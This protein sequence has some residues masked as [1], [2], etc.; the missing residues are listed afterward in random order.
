MKQ[1]WFVQ[2]PQVFRTELLREAH[3][4][5]RAENFLGTDDAQLVERLGVD[6]CVV[7][8][9]AAN[10]KI[11]Q[12]VDLMLGERLL[13]EAGERIVES[14]DQFPCEN[15]AGDEARPALHPTPPTAC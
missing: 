8:A 6:V 10:P 9:Q 7:E 14:A 4:K 2:T 11:T 1:L 3:A 15:K 12:P 5:A 13:A